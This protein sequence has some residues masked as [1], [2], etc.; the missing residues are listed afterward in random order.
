[1]SSQ[2]ML[3]L[4]KLIYDKSEDGTDEFIQKCFVI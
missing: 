3:E 2:K 4:I 1:M